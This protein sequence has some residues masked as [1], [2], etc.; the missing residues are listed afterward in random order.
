MNNLEQDLE[1]RLKKLEEKV[2]RNEE[3]VNFMAAWIDKN[4]PR[5]PYNS[6]LDGPVMFGHKYADQLNET[7]PRNFST[8]FNEAI[9]KARKD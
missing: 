2:A 4:V 7:K 6:M 5:K 9:L 3:I 1:E 8:D